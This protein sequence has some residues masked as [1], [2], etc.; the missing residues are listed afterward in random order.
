MTGA[1][2]LSDHGVNCNRLDICVGD[3]VRANKCRLCEAGIS[4]AV[5]LSAF[6]NSGCESWRRRDQTELNSSLA[7]PWAVMDIR[8][9]CRI[10]VQISC[11]L[12]KKNIL[13]K[14]SEGSF[15][16]CLA[17]RSVKQ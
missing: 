2:L 16:C 10:L 9:K 3:M 1:G 4:H 5:G 11:I 8:G 17:G 12:K 7:P 15:S 14:Y 6:R 13:M